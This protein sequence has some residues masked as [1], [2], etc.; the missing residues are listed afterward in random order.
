MRG[1]RRLTEPEAVRP[2]R[3]AGGGGGFL[4]RVSQVFL[5]TDDPDDV[6]LTVPVKC[7]QFTLGPLDQDPTETGDAF[8]VL[9]LI[10][11]RK[12]LNVSDFL[13]A[14]FSWQ[15]YHPQIDVGDIVVVQRFS[16]MQ[17]QLAYLETI[18][19]TVCDHFIVSRQYEKWDVRN[20]LTPPCN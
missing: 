10:H 12:P 19:A 6:F 4:A 3:G 11:G 8:W 2:S 13:A 7:K 5:N 14:P 1:A 9:P 20:T 18:P 16:S 15:L 17:V